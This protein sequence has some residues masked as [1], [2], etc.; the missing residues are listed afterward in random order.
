METLEKMRSD[1]DFNF[2]YDLI[3]KKV[4]VIRGIGK[5]E[6][7]TKKTY[8]FVP[9]CSLLVRWK[10]NSF[11]RC[12]INSESYFYEFHSTFDG[13]RYYYRENQISKWY[14][15]CSTWKS[16]SMAIRTE[17]WLLL[18][19]SQRR[20][21]VLAISNSSKSLVDRLPLVKVASFFNNS[22]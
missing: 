20:F 22:R 1:R 15:T 13:K 11:W 10:S 4:S 14:H 5:P 3:R 21:I 18:A 7:R 6:L 16:F 12:L 19:M 17:T 9:C 2:C 8:Q